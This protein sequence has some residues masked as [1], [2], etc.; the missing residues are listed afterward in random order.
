MILSDPYCPVLADVDGDG[1]PDPVANGSW[2]ENDG[3]P[4]ETFISGSQQPCDTFTTADLDGDGDPDFLATA[5]WRPNPGTDP[6]NPD[7]D[8]DGLSDGVETDTGV[9][10]DASNTGTDPHDPDTDGDGLLDSVETNTGVFI[11][12]NDRGTDPHD[13]DTDGDGLSDDIE[14]NSGV[15]VNANDPGTSPVDADT[16]GDGLSDSAEIFVQGSNPLLSDTDGDGLSDGA[17]LFRIQTLLFDEFVI[18]AGTDIVDVVAA[19]LDGDGDPDAL[20]GPAQPV[21]LLDFDGSTDRAWSAFAVDLDGDMDLDVVSSS[22]DFEFFAP[23][24]FI[25]W[26][27][28]R[29]DTHGDFVVELIS[30]AGGNL[31]PFGFNSGINAVDLDLDGDPDVLSGAGFWY[32]NR[33]DEPSQDF[34]T[35]LSGPRGGDIAVIDLDGDQVLDA[36]SRFND[37]SWYQGSVGAAF[38]LA[39]AIGPLGG[40]INDPVDAADLDGDGDADVLAG[41]VGWSENLGGAIFATQVAIAPPS[42]AM[43]GGSVLAADLDRDGDLDVVSDAGA[44]LWSENRLGEPIADF[45]APQSI[46]SSITTSQVVSV[47]AADFDRDGNL[48]LLSNLGD[49]IAWHRNP[50]TDL[51]NPDTDGDGL[52]DGF[53]AANGFNPSIGGE[54][55]EDP[56]A[57]GL[58]NLAEQT[59][60]TDPNDP[61]SDDDTFS[62]GAEVAAGTDPNDPLDFPTA[63]VPAL[64]P[65]GLV[66][67]IALLGATPWALRRRRKLGA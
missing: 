48:D 61:D 55:T 45:A 43:F 50:N 52:L 63:A 26:S 16:D 36:V 18:A 39:Q 31:P 11:D 3:T 41:D 46:G 35:G 29:L 5:E 51:L 49:G 53:E 37:L 33:L 56:D 58:D 17:E 60:A 24:I 7:T 14:T 65:G 34:D 9:C 10:L 27:E 12:A 13:A 4:H 42:G 20:F 25:A 1:D 8:G 23:T 22:D 64:S 44:I 62:D 54:Q 21:A 30:A 2:V 15:F 6:L 32:R 57:D 19:D 28:N 47:V 38:G 59:A 66:V 67:L 40:N